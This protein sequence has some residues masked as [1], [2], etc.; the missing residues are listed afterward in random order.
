M[1]VWT[2]ERYYI[3]GGSELDGVFPTKEATEAHRNS[4]HHDPE[5]WWI[6]E[7]DVPADQPDAARCERCSDSGWIQGDP[8]RG[9]SDEPCGC[10]E[11]STVTA[12]EVKS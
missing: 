5:D 6:K 12:G 10:D 2:L 8:V 1:K 7:W 4:S 11:A 9:I 3:E